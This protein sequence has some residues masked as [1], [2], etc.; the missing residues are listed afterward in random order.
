MSDSEFDPRFGK[1]WR[2]GGQANVDG[3]IGKETLRPRCSNGPWVAIERDLNYK[4]KWKSIEKVY[5]EQIWKKKMQYEAKCT[6]AWANRP[7][8]KKK[9]KKKKKK[10]GKK[11]RKKKKKKKKQEKKKRHKKPGPKCLQRGASLSGREGGGPML[12]TAEVCAAACTVSPAGRLRCDP[13]SE[14]SQT[15][16]LHQ[17]WLKPLGRARALPGACRDSR[18]EGGGE[19]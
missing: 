10:E 17:C 19:S 2:I 16:R 11:E 6:D 5:I 15:P 4:K 8:Q 14:N 13:G 1:D 7:R 3:G 18:R 9:K 12:Q